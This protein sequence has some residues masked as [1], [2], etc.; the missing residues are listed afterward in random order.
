MSEKSSC[1]RAGGDKNLDFHSIFSPSSV[2]MFACIGRLTAY[3]QSMSSKGHGLHWQ[4]LAS[5]VVAQQL[6]SKREKSS[7]CVFHK[8]ENRREGKCKRG[9]KKDILLA[10][11]FFKVIEKT[12]KA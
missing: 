11:S 8:Q 10:S 5:A 7:T 2:C 3:T 12:S 9:E 1:E 6:T 4:V